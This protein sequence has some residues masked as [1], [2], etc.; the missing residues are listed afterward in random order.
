MNQQIKR[1]EH[2]DA[3]QA[4]TAVKKGGMALILLI[5]VSLIWSLAADRY[6]PFTTQARVEAYVVGVA[7]K[8]AGEV[9]QV[10][11]K[12]NQ[13]VEAGDRLF[14]IDPTNYQIAVQKAQADLE[15]AGRQVGAGSA[16]VDTAR[17]NLVAAQANELKA[18][19]D[20]SRL[21]RLF[22]DDPGTISKRRLE[23]AKASLDQAKAAVMAREADIDRAIEQ[24][25]G[26][27]DSNS[28]LLKNAR[29]ALNKA[30]LDLE[31]TVVRAPSKGVISDL[32]ADVGQFA[33]AGNPVMTLIAIHDVCNLGNLAVGSRVE[34]L[35]D[36]MPG[37]VF[38]GRIRSIGLG[39]SSGQTK[40]AGKLPSI[41]NDRDWLRQAQR[42]PVIIEFALDQDPN[43]R[44]QLRVGG[45]ASVIAYAEN[46][47]V[48][49]T[50]ARFYIRLMSLLSYA[51]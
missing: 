50:L 38:E 43:L 44:T 1:D 16:A 8:V 51:Y 30:K 37:T 15:N 27:D 25:G 41:S 3:A 4:D 20:Y 31:D 2:D 47:G 23:V 9:T 11:V 7:P 26:A 5:L 49:A 6:T 17:A 32:R 18:R 45:Q 12:N 28:T 21:K 46:S 39:V 48:L 36:S 24:K 42:F 33:G 14:E 29:V 13:H 40:P 10:W 35:F 19:Q 34:L 22:D